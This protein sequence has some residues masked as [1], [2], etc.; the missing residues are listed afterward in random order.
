MAIGKLYAQD[1]LEIKTAAENY[2]LAKVTGNTTNI[3]K[4]TP[5]IYINAIGGKKALIQRSQNL[6]ADMMKADEVYLGM[7]L[8]KIGGIIK[9]KLRLYRIVEVNQEI[10]TI[11][12][13][14]N[15]VVL[16]VGVHDDGNKWK[17][18]EAEDLNIPSVKSSYED[19]TSIIKI[20]K[21][22]MRVFKSKQH[23]S[24]EMVAYNR[25]FKA[26]VRFYELEYKEPKGYLVSDSSI[27]LADSVAGHRFGVIQRSFRS[28]DG[29]LIG[30]TFNGP[31]VDDGKLDGFPGSDGLPY[32][33]N[34]NWIP[35]YHW[36]YQ[37]LPTE[38]TEQTYNADLSAIY[39]F[40][41]H[42]NVPVLAKNEK[43]RS[44][45][46]HKDY[47]VDIQVMYFYTAESEHLLQKH[48]DATKHMLRF[49]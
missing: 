42:K 47:V 5:T 30:I 36:K 24:D 37:V 39:Q 45:I 28:K 44:V 48:M 2:A 33:P 6:K 7:S 20:P 17:F 32:H 29:I 10:K 43:C 1:S 19:L 27:T 34:K 8:H 40:Y 4:N 13:I 38:Y 26:K 3:I 31:I 11:G 22:G 12:G 14:C 18:F 21:R 9:S 41:Q 35:M 49:K 16:Y 15:F 25:S 46:I 23:F